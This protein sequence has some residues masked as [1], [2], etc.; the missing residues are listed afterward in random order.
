MQIKS[1]EVPD[2]PEGMEE[3]MKAS[4]LLHPGNSEAICVINPNK[5]VGDCYTFTEFNDSFSALLEETGIEGYRIMRMDLRLDSYNPN[6]YKEYAKMHKFLL[7]C[8]AVA[9][10]VK[11][12]YKTENLFTNKLLSMAIKNDYLQCECYDR[13]EKSKLTKN[14]EEKGLSRLEERTMSKEWRKILE[15]ESLSN[16]EVIKEEFVNNWIKRWKKAISLENIKKCEE[17][18]NAA[19]ADLYAEGK[20][21]FPVQF[22]TLTDFL[23]QYQYCIFSS[24]QMVN[25]LKR[26]GVENAE[27]RAKNHKKRYGIEYFSQS[28]LKK[29]V[30]EIDRATKKFFSE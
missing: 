15:D 6:H 20:D 30:A 18:Y 22:R 5:L 12:V 2:I 17:T 19:L 28:D 4:V 23:I 24:R 16:E 11:N 9:Y 26:I 21:A 27:V 1:E 3:V 10:E 7:S 25:L 14:H 8:L 29:A 13:K